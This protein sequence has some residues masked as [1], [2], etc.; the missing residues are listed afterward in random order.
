M[1]KRLV[2][3][4]CTLCILP[5][6]WAYQDMEQG[7]C[8]YSWEPRCGDLCSEVHQTCN[9]G[10]QSLLNIEQDKYCC[11]KDCEYDM[12]NEKLESGSDVNCTTGQVISMSKRCSNKC[13]NDYEDNRFL[14]PTGHYTCPFSQECL[15]VLQMCQG[16]SCSDSAVAECDRS[17]KCSNIKTGIRRL[18]TNI[19]R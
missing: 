2:L 10:N 14:G 16:V 6:D 12:S 18:T 4:M 1:M 13:Y 9:C 11:A 3:L 7:Q 5:E 17:L 8:Q 15:P 19:V